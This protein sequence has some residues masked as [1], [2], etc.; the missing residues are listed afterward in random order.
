MSLKPGGNAPARREN[1]N[2]GVVST[3]PSAQNSERWIVKYI[4]PFL[5]SNRCKNPQVFLHAVVFKLP[6]INHLQLVLN[7]A[8]KLAKS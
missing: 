5:Y 2:D 3:V 7:F 8:K 4:I 6:A 1:E